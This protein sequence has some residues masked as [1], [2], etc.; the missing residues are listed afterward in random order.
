MRILA[1]A[2]ILSL[3]YVARAQNAQFKGVV[4]DTIKIGRAHV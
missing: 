2:L 4:K 1:L 3:P